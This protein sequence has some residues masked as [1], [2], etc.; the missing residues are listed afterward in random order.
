MER[1]SDQAAR[2]DDDSAAAHPVKTPA[3]G[4]GMPA[5]A[6]SPGA[7]RRLTPERIASK[8]PTGLPAI[9][10]ARYTLEHGDPV[11]RAAS[12]IVTLDNANMGA[13]DSS[14]DVDGKSFDAHR[15]ASCW[16]DNVIH[17]NASLDDSVASPDEGLAGIESRR[18]GALPA[19]ETRAGWQ[20]S[21]TGLIDA[22]R[23]T[24]ARTEHV[25]RLEPSLPVALAR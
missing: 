9:D 21:H 12:R 11:R 8:T 14:V 13:S 19:V 7:P 4:H 16:Q 17:S 15:D 10:R 3:P 22:L 18:G 6:A 20:V 24:G 23:T 25:I 5:E 2:R 1:T